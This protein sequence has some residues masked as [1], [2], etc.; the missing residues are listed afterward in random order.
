MMLP[1]T[2]LVI[3]F[4][5]GCT[6]TELQTGL[7]LDSDS[8]P[9]PWYERIQYYFKSL[10]SRMD[11]IVSGDCQSAINHLEDGVIRLPNSSSTLNVASIPVDDQILRW[12]RNIKQ[13]K[14]MRVDPNLCDAV[15]TKKRPIFTNKGCHLNG[16]MSASAPRCQN[17]Y[18]QYICNQSRIAI[19]DPVRNGFFL[20]ESNHFST[21]LPPQPWLMTASNSF[22]SMCGQIS[23]DCGLVRTT[24]NCMGTGSEN[25]ANLF[26]EKCPLSL[27]K[28]VSL[29][30]LIDVWCVL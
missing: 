25:S 5:I 10:A 4:A 17:K 2:I 30:T 8:E 1:S 26:R 7:S 19:D 24:A 13:P 23:T 9:Y 27:T 22:V 16:Y 12:W 18:L 29:L 14:Q 6:P 11:G 15:M 20:P 3:L 21:E 28:D